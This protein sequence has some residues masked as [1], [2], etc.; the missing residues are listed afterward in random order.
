MERTDSDRYIDSYKSAF[1]GLPP[2]IREAEVNAE[3]HIIT[4]ITVE[5]GRISRIQS[6]SGTVLFVRVNGEKTGMVYTEDLDEDAMQVIR[7]AYENSFCSERKEAELLNRESMVPTGDGGKAIWDPAVLERIAAGMERELLENACR[8]RRVYVS[9]KAETTGQRVVNSHGVDVSFCSPVYVMRVTATASDGE[10]GYSF[11][12]T[13]TALDP[14]AFEPAEFLEDLETGLAFQMHPV[15]GFVSGDYPV[16]LE[17]NVVRNIFVTT[18]QLFSGV[19][20][21]KGDGALCGLLSEMIGSS[22][23][24]ITDYP[25]YPG[26]GFYFPCDCEGTPGKPVKLVDQ[27]IL[28]GLMTNLSASAALKVAPTGNAGRRPM[29]SGNIATDIVVTPR[30][31]VV[32]P[33]ESS[34]EEMMEHMGDGIYLM[35]SSDVFHTVNLSSGDFCIPCKGVRIRNGQSAEHFGSLH[36]SGNMKDFFHRIVEVGDRLYLSTMEDLENFG[37]IT[38]A[39]RLSSCHVSGE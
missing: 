8:I 27:G 11:S 28:T 32:E 4:D 3:T 19:R 2:G 9:L 17:K 18:W 5:N 33:Q 21:A 10:N 29:L 16:I 26:S 1:R 24:N 14:E 37:I 39:L 30:N 12:C 35:D 15:S 23:L 34:I 31:L 13:R 7:R 20:Y 38:P 25:S 22:L 6:A 36:I